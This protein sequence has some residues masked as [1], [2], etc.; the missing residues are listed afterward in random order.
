MLSGATS[1]TLSAE[2]LAEEVALRTTVE[3]MAEEAGPPKFDEGGIFDMV[4]PP[5]GHLNSLGSRPTT[6]SLPPAPAPANNGE[7]R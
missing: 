5:G 3:T 7:L 2:A 1:A 4:R 6:W